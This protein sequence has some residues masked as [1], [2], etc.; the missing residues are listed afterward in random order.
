MDLKQNVH[1]TP[2]HPPTPSSTPDLALAGPEPG[3]LRGLRPARTHV[4]RHRRGALASQRPLG[5]APLERRALSAA[6]PSAA[7]PPAGPAR[8]T[9]QL[10][11]L[12]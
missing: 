12:C 5:K 8:S 10:A 1:Q 11:A 2:Q 6:V 9:P 3:L 7:Q 4:G